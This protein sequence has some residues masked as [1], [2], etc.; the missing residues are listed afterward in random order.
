M[1]L[2]LEAMKKAEEAKRLRMRAEP[3]LEGAEPSEGPLLQQAEDTEIP[4]PEAGSA[5]LEFPQLDTTEDAPIPAS[6]T[7]EL[8]PLTFES[9]SADA[10]APQAPAS[11]E[12]GTES[13]AEDQARLAAAA[14]RLG[15]RKSSGS[16]LELVSQP[17]PAEPT[18]SKA[19]AQEAPAPQPAAEEVLV[20]Q[21]PAAAVSAPP[22]QPVINPTSAPTTAPATPAQTNVSATTGTAMPKPSPKAAQALFD[23][24]KPGNKAQPKRLIAVAAVGLIALGGVSAWLW[25][26]LNGANSLASSSLVLNNPPPSQVPAAGANPPDSAAPTPAAT[27]A[28]AEHAA[29]P[30]ATTPVTP[31][32]EAPSAPV[33]ATQPSTQTSPA[34]QPATSSNTA[35]PAAPP[36]PS[37]STAKLAPPSP[38]AK[39]GGKLIEV[40][41]ASADHEIRFVRSESSPTIPPNVTFGYEAFQRGELSRAAE[42]YRRAFEADPHNRDAMLGLAAIAAKRGRLEEARQWYHR[43]LAE[44][45]T[46]EAARSALLALGDSKDP[47]RT[48]ARLKQAV[49]EQADP[50]A[51]AALGAFYAGRGQWTEAQQYYFRAYSLAPDNPDFAYNLAIGLD[52]LGERKLAAEYYRKALN[53]ADK[54]GFSFDKATV[55][56]RLET[57]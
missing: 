15:Q 3:S 19:D 36:P 45:P 39:D 54:H 42:F 26:K 47:A 46:D 5:N 8:A 2:L 6:S 49:E 10:G 55:A 56:R 14:N 31:P 40:A 27:P 43:L 29:A 33:V 30:S 34:S 12:V 38:P 18:D 23:T 22:P 13:S 28:P 21:A 50:Q 16:G 32:A 11:Q 57:L 37:G 1:S 7:L 25:W 35:L 4:K 17:T 41:P 20:T 44:Y 52:N 53:L 24:K 51:A 9:S 48:E